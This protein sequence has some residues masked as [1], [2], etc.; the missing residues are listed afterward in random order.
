MTDSIE[1]LDLQIAEQEVII[2]F[3]EKRIANLKK[4]KHVLLDLGGNLDSA[5]ADAKQEPRKR[6]TT[7]VSINKSTDI[8]NDGGANNREDDLLVLEDSP[9]SKVMLD[10]DDEEYVPAEVPRK[11]KGKAVSKKAVS[12]K[13]KGSRTVADKDGESDEE[14]KVKKVRGRAVKGKKVQKPVLDSSIESEINLAF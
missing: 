7:M 1:L 10:D 3:A 5:V 13:A 9:M 8:E 12:G 2:E 6:S 11:V 14:P 4:R